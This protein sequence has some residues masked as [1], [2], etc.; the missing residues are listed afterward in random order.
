MQ[1]QDNDIIYKSYGLDADFFERI[2]GGF[3]NADVSVS[4]IVSFVIQLWTIYSIFAFALSALFIY[5]IIYSYIRVG[6]LSEEQEAKLL[7]QEKMWKELHGGHIE[8]ER[9]HSVQTHLSSENPNDWKLAIIEADVLLERML[10]K[11]GYAG[12]T[13]GEKLKSASVRSFATLDDAWQAHRVRNQIAHGGTDFVL[14][15][16]VAKETLVLYERVFKEFSY[17]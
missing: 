4:G 1:P 8:N 3:A 16:K 9:W 7:E 17:L 14:T 11:A 2:F 5:G 6:Q 12:T 15:Q 10:E 13:I